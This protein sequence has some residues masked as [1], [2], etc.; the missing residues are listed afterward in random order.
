MGNFV[1][2]YLLFSY[3]PWLPED[4]RYDFHEQSLF[5]LAVNDGLKFVLGFAGSFISLALI[6]KY[7]P[8]LKG[9]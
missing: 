8:L 6:H 3:M 4:F 1:V 2:A 5:Q 9:T 7:L